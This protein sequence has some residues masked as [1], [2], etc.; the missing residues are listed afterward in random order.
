M[1]KLVAIK[2]LLL[3]SCKMKFAYV[4]QL[5]AFSLSSSSRSSSFPINEIEQKRHIEQLKKADDALI[6]AKKS[7]IIADEANKRALEFL[8]KT[9]IF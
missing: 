4:F 1:F 5:L 3:R 2:H 6:S 7:Q 8:E 9:K